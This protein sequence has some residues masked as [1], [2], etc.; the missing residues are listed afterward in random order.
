MAAGDI[1]LSSGVTITAA[2]IQQIAA[3]VEKNLAAKSKELSQFEEVTSLANV[4]SLPGIQQ[5]GA[6]LKLVRVAL[7]VLKGVDGKNIE[8][9]ASQTAIQ[10]RNVGKQG[11]QRR[12]GGHRRE[13]RYGC[14]RCHRRER[15][16]WR[17]GH[18]PKRGDRHRVEVRRRRLVADARPH[19]RP[20]VHLRRADRRAE[21]GNLPP[22]HPRHGGSRQGRHPLRQLHR[23]RHGRPRQPEV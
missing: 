10:W 5:S 14:H 1:I 7:E 23:R 21:A 9:T 12:Q 4:S 6:T 20:L 2:E 19:G 3:E 11:R 18:A 13:G 15:R 8:L 16:P 22:P 17:E